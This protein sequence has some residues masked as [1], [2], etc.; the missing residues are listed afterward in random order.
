MMKM[1]DYDYNKMLVELQQMDYREK[2]KK[3]KVIIK[4]ISKRINNKI[5][6]NNNK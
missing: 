2:N 6:F 5:L 3:E 1:N 4:I